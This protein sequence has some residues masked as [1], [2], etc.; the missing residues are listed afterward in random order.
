MNV[1]QTVDEV[2]RN[3]CSNASKEVRKLVKGQRY[4]ILGNKEDFSLNKFGHSSGREVIGASYQQV[5]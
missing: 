5:S 3:H 1:N 4:L 2:R